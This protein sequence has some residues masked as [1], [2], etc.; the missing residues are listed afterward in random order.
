M[1]VSEM[2]LQQTQVARVQPKWEAFMERWPTAEAC[3]EASLD[4][5]LREWQG[6]GYPRR[7]LALHRCAIAVADRGWP[8]GEAALRELPGVGLYTA[9]ALLALAFEAPGPPPLDVNIARVAARAALGV[10]AEDARRREIEAAVA[11]GQPR[12]LKRRDYVLALF[13][14]G[15][16]HCRSVPRC[17][18][19]PLASGCRSRSRLAAPARPAANARRQPPYAGSFRQLR[20]QVL[21]AMLDDPRPPGRQALTRRLR[22]LTPAPTAG[23]IARAVESLVADGLVTASR[24]RRSDG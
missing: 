1:L 19:C 17:N 3:A 10:E 14:A 2:M 9:R 18:G 21:A 7:A 5:V 6:L 22:R 15:A 12:G 13:D 23:A 4:D 16:I 24:V 11:S 8:E 20:G